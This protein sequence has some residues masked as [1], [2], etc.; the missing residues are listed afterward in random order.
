MTLSMQMDL[1][2]HAQR[3]EQILLRPRLLQEGAQPEAPCCCDTPG[4][5]HTP[6]GLLQMSR[7]RLFVSSTTFP[8]VPGPHRCCI[9]DVHHSRDGQESEEAWGQ[10]AA[11]GQNS[12]A[13]PRANSS[14]PPP[15]PN[16]CEFQVASRNR[17]SKGGSRPKDPIFVSVVHDGPLR[18]NLHVRVA[19]SPFLPRRLPA[20]TLHRLFLLHQLSCLCWDVVQVIW[21]LVLRNGTALI[22]SFS[23]VH[24][25]RMEIL[26]SCSQR[27]QIEF[28]LILNHHTQLLAFALKAFQAYLHSPCDK[29]Q[30]KIPP[31]RRC[32]ILPHT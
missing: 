14:R 23:K 16:C 12:P 3:V 1:F 10:M 24:A 30:G 11:G 8:G 20:R 19:Q 31:S 29:I 6:R 2:A 18:S 25:I 26:W 22:S 5:S 21:G 13:T 17:L 28:P 15:Q 7:R 27:A 32:P 9:K 4:A